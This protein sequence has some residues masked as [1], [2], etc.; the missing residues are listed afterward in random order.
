MCSLQSVT[1]RPGALGAQGSQ[2]VAAGNDAHFRSID[3]GM[4][5]G[6]GHAIISLG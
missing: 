3:T 4:A 2:R 5:S 1:L 6:T